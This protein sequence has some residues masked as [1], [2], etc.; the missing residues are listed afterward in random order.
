MFWP[1]MENAREKNAKKSKQWTYYRSEK[2]GK[3]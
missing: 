1:R 2:E 3:A